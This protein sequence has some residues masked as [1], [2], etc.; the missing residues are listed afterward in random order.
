[1]KPPL[2]SYPVMEKKPR[3]PRRGDRIALISPAPFRASLPKELPKAKVEMEIL[4][5][6]MVNSP[7]FSGRYDGKL[8]INISL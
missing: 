3:S 1:M 5:R 7:S 2:L 4:R 8:P 6:Q